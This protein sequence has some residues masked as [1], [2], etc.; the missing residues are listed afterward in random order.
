MRDGRA[1]FRHLGGRTLGGSDRDSF[2]LLNRDGVTWDDPLWLPDQ[3]R[4]IGVDDHLTG[5]QTANPLVDG[6]VAK[7]TEAAHQDVP[8]HRPHNDKNRTA[9]PLT[10]RRQRAA[11][12]R[13]ADPH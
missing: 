6:L 11:D 7:L 10:T 5:D 3:Q 13:D 4:T 1:G 12:E 8:N 9:A 2:E